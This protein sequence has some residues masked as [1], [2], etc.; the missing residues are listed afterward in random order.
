MSA[1][2]VRVVIRGEVQGVGFRWSAQSEAQRL[3]L[4]GWVRNLPSG[5]VEAE[6]E[7]VTQSVEAFV[8]WCKRGPPSARVEAVAVEDSYVLEDRRGFHIRHGP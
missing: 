4:S 7:G 5:E 2:R 3:G 8:A 1:K 6:V